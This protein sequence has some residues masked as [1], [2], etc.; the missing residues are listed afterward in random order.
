MGLIKVTSATGNSIY[1]NKE[2]VLTIHESTTENI[3]IIKLVNGEQ[4][5]VQEN[6]DSFADRLSM[7]NCIK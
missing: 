5:K 4:L 7:V 2:H 1:L 3:I 6:L